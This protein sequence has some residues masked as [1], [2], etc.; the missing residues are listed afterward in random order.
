MQITKSSRHSEYERMGSYLT[1][2]ELE[3][4]NYYHYEGY[5]HHK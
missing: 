4:S 1:V 2:S 3:A 5:R